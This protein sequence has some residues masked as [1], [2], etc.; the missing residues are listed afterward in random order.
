MNCHLPLPP[1]P[2]EKNWE[3][4]DQA[5]DPES[6]WNSESMRLVKEAAKRKVFCCKGYY[7]KAFRLGH[8][9]FSLF[10]DPAKKEWKI[11]T[12]LHIGGHTAPPAAYGKS[13]C[14]SY[15]FSSRISTSIISSLTQAKN[16][17]YS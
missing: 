10:R 14:W 5:F 3:I 11:A 4:C 12:R 6:L 15:S 2:P 13:G 17:L 9:A 7:I 1:C 16:D 8:S